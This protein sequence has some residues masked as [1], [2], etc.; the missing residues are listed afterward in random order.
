M[1]SEVDVPY[2]VFAG[3]VL[4]LCCKLGR[5]VLVEGACG[6][7]GADARRGLRAARCIRPPGVVAVLKLF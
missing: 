2:V 7:P 1:G 4:S 3:L 6:R 5:G